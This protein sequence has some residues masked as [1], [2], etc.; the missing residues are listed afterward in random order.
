MAGIQP[1]FSK[2][3]KTMDAKNVV[4]NTANSFS[5]N[6]DFTIPENAGYLR[7]AMNE[8]HRLTVVEGKEHKQ[9]ANVIGE[10]L[11]AEA[12]RGKNISDQDFS[13]L[14]LAEFFLER[15]ESLLKGDAAVIA[16]MQKAVNDRLGDFTPY[17]AQ[18]LAPNAPL[19]DPTL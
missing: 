2:A 7:T 4:L 13:D 19:Y 9:A 11:A 3:A 1:Q 5:Q 16:T 18:G 6:F 17:V 8:Y 15:A 10:Q 12:K 14:Q